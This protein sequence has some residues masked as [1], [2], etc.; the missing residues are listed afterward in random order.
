[1]RGVVLLFSLVLFTLG[2]CGYTVVSKGAS[3]FAGRSLA[4]APFVNSSYQPEVE[5][6]LRRALVDE[7]AL[8]SSMVLSAETSAD[9]L[10][11]GEIESLSLE[12]TAFSA[13]D[14]ARL[15]RVTLVAQATALD[16][17][18]GKVLWKGKH[19]VRQ[20]YPANTVMGLQR[21]AKETA[22]AS[23]CVEMARQLMFLMN[24]SF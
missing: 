6:E 1:V 2:G 4:V 20:E 15:Y 8:G 5:G 19:T 7:I 12:P 13:G 18:S 3:P 11:S 17:Q 24:R 22:I 10:L 9:I 23:A 14:K 16:R 21:N